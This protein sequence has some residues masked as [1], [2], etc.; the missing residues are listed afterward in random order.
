MLFP[1]MLCL[2]DSQETR[3]CI[4][5]STADKKCCYPESRLGG[6]KGVKFE[7][8]FPSFDQNKGSVITLFE[9]V[10]SNNS[11][12][13]ILL[14]SRTVSISFDLQISLSSLL[15]RE[16]MGIL[17]RSSVVWLLPTQLDSTCLP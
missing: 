5:E 11:T 15:M 9:M 8:N 12:N 2:F 6:E 17:T 3:W 10:S 16:K 7:D 4:N 13:L 14:R 1:G